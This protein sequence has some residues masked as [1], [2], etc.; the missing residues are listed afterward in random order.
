MADAHAK[1]HDYHLV[2]PSPWPAVGTIAADLEAERAVELQAAGKAAA[3]KV[4]SPVA[5]VAALNE[6]PK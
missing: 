4:D 3:A 1:Q 6:Q 2:D 5:A